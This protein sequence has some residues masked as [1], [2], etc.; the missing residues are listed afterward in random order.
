MDFGT[1]PGRQDKWPADAN[2]YCIHIGEKSTLYC[3]DASFSNSELNGPVFL[4]SG[5]H[6]LLLSTTLESN[7]GGLFVIISE[8][9]TLNKI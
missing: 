2:D 9:E 3:S 1:L 5:R 7:S 8:K 4:S 6:R